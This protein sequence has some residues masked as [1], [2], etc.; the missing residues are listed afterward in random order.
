VLEHLRDLLLRGV[1][2]GS[3]AA[4]GVLGL[5]YRRETLIQLQSARP[6]PSGAAG[7]QI[8]SRSLKGCEAARH[9]TGSGATP[10]RESNSPHGVETGKVIRESRIPPP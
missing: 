4:G 9:A 3:R 6:P 10:L 8:V 7:P 1:K 2:W 5:S